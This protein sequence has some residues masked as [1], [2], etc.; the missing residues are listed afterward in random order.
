[1][2]QDDSLSAKRGARSSPAVASNS[3]SAAG[4]KVE[5]KVAVRKGSTPR[6][7]EVKKAPKRYAYANYPQQRRRVITR[8]R[9][10]GFN[11]MRMVQRARY[12][13]KRAI[14]QIF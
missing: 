12:H 4:K 11:P 6:K 10:Q 1:V 7:S 8:T 5:K 9:D 13:I 3:R 14:H 2:A